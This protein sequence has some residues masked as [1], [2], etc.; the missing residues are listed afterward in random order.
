MHRTPVRYLTITIALVASLLGQRPNF[1]PPKLFPAGSDPSFAVVADFND[2]G[3]SDLAIANVGYSSSV[4]TVTI[5]LGNGNGGFSLAGS[6]AV[7]TAGGVLAV[8]D[9]NGDGKLDIVS[10]S[11]GL[12]ILLGNG[13]GTFQPSTSLSLEAGPAWVT[14]GDFNRDGKQD[15]AVT[16]SDQG[17]SVL[18]G[19]GDGTFQ[20]PTFY[21]TQSYPGQVIAA[22]FNGDGN[23]DLAL[24]AEGGID[25]PAASAR[26]SPRAGVS[27]LLGRGDGTFSKP[28]HYTT[29]INPESLAAYDFRG[30]GRLDL[31]VSQAGQFPTPG[32]V[33]VLP[34]NGDGT[35]RKPRTFASGIAGGSLALADFNGDGKIDLAIGD[36]SG[37]ARGTFWIVPGRGDG[38]FGKPVAYTVAGDSSQIWNLAVGAFTRAKAPALVVPEPQSGE[39][40]LLVDRPR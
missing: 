9:F 38:S 7:G 31:V 35:F 4:G 32:S 23:L 3:N 40:A 15:L 17:V 1:A 18:L 22:D 30:D 21:R 14:T 37:T 16:F 11:G 13:D 39:V 19:N 26:N 20:A 8:A 12:S 10:T 28:V 33:R 25:L 29:G 27:V 24:F 5:L 6:N 2:D 36:G 34:G